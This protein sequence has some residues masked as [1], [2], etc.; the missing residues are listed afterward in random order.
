MI[1]RSDTQAFRMSHDAVWV[2]VNP[3]ETELAPRVWKSISDASGAVAEDHVRRCWRPTR[4]LSRPVSSDDRSA[5]SEGALRLRAA[6]EQHTAS[7]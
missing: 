5:E 7:M 2:G 1:R 6:C 4:P 3:G